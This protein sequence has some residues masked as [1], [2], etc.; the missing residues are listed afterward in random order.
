MAELRFE[1]RGLVIAGAFSPAMLHPAWFVEHELIRPDEGGK[2]NVQVISSEITL[3]ELPWVSVQVSQQRLDLVCD[4]PVSYEAVRDLGQGTL[5]LLRG[6]RVTAIGMNYYFHYAVDGMPMALNRFS[7]LHEARS[8]SLTSEPF[9]TQMKVRTGRPEALA[10]GI[11]GFFAIDLQPSVQ[12][13]SGGVFFGMNDHYDL[14]QTRGSDLEGR[15]QRLLTE[16]WEPSRDHA[17]RVAEAVIADI[18][19]GDSPIVEAVVD[20]GQGNE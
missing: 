17:Q 19:H 14:K 15:V 11:D 10:P 7:G 6:N 3:W 4:D 1:G 16:A 2:A 18:E 8:W 20:G 5:R 12:V 13:K 9:V